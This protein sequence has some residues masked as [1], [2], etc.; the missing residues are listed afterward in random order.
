MDDIELENNIHVKELELLRLIEDDGN[1]YYSLGR[2][3]QDEYRYNPVGNWQ[4][5]M[6]PGLPA[7]TCDAVPRPCIYPTSYP[8]WNVVETLGPTK[9][10]PNYPETKVDPKVKGGWVYV[11]DKVRVERRKQVVDYPAHLSKETFSNMK[12]SKNFKKKVIYSPKN[13]RP[14]AIDYKDVVVNLK[15][16]GLGRHRHPPIDADRLIV[17]F[18]RLYIYLTSLCKERTILESIVFS[19]EREANQKYILPADV[20]VAGHVDYALQSLSVELRFVKT[21][22]H[23]IQEKCDDTSLIKLC[24]DHVGNLLAAVKTLNVFNGQEMLLNLK[25]LDTVH[26]VDNVLSDLI[27]HIRYMGIIYVIT[28]QKLLVKET[29]AYEGR[30]KMFV[31]R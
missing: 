6:L 27:I 19:R 1:R 5:K 4:L 25:N 7:V 3:P 31:G 14:S 26:K 16:I 23:S 22:F 11:S 15:E 24:K 10:L 17:K 8:S 30:R 13:A 9:I 29:A 18:R 21:I 28:A 20:G 2:G 12:K